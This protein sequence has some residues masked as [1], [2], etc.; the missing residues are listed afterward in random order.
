[1]YMFQPAEAWLLDVENY[2]EFEQSCSVIG[3]VLFSGDVNILFFH[4]GS[5]QTQA[6]IK[7]WDSL[8]PRNDDRFTGKL[9]KSVYENSL[10]LVVTFT[11]IPKDEM[12]TFCIRLVDSVGD[13]RDRLNTPD[14]LRPDV[15]CKFKDIVVS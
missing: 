11:N 1:M 3:G 12:K 14:Y 8:R 6:V 5:D 7:L 2:L 15:M 9:K 4:E 10:T 13:L